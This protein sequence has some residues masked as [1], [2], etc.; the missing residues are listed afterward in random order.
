MA[1]FA[2][3]AVFL[4]AFATAATA[5]PQQEA[6]SQL[7]DKWSWNDCG[8]SN[9]PLHVTSISISPDPPK[10]GEDLT[11]TAR[12]TLSSDLKEGAYADVAVKVGRIKILQKEFDLC[13][14][15]RSANA[16]IQCPVTAGEHEIT[17]TVK[18]PK[19]I[20]PAP[21]N[22]HIDG[23]TIDDEDLLCLDLTID[24]RKSRFFGFVQD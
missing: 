3:L 22:V 21:F 1:R 19:E 17:H 7:S 14:E 8:A 9:I 2:I 4:T 10:T 13:E 23:Y 5:L 15:A 6:L 12:G 11:V 16:S 24:F 20:P 18:L